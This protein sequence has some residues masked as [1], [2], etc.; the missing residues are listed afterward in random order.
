MVIGPSD[1]AI[2]DIFKMVKSKLV[3]TAGNKA[4]YNKYSFVCVYDLVDAIIKSLDKKTVTTDDYFIAHEN[5]ITFEDIIETISKVMN[6]KI[7][8]L[9]MPV[10]L[11]KFIANILSKLPFDFRL[12]PDKINELIEPSWVC[13]NDKSLKNLRM[14]YKWNLKET[15]E[16]TYQDYKKRNWI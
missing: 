1:P 12:T 2:L 7:F 5:I 6:K 16:I 11:L 13:K 14:N 8:Y 15:I 9:S 10:A 3:L 4:K